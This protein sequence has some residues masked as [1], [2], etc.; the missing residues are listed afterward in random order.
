MPCPVLYCQS[1]PGWG[2]GDHSFPGINPLEGTIK[3]FISLCDCFFGIVPA[4]AGSP[5]PPRDLLQT[6]GCCPQQASDLVLCYTCPLRSPGLTCSSRADL[7]GCSP[8]PLPSSRLLLFQMPGQQ[9]SE[10]PDLTL[11]WVDVVTTDRKR[12]KA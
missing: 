4:L 2:Y 5:W 7:P 10:L 6:G 3:L 12:A 8:P 11:T 1:P 9:G